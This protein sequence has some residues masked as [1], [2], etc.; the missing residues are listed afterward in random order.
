MYSAIRDNVGRSPLVVPPLV[1]LPIHPSRPPIG[2]DPRDTPPGS[3][4]PKSGPNGDSSHS[5]SCCTIRCWSV[6]H[7]APCKKT[8]DAR[9]KP[10]PGTQR[11]TQRRAGTD[12]AE[13]HTRTATPA[14][15]RQG[16]KQW[17]AIWP[18][19]AAQA[20]SHPRDT[21]HGSAPPGY[22]PAWTGYP[23]GHA[24]MIIVKYS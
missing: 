5:R 21:P 4:P 13:N 10:A 23:L 24:C 20:V 11:Q 3:A 1:V 22:E 17:A 8:T 2:P 14:P 15:H 19:A 18:G 9:R 12:T 7:Y 6:D 16:R